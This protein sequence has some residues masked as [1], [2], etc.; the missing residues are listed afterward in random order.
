MY[1][2]VSVIRCT[3]MLLALK[4]QAWANYRRQCKAEARR[5]G[6]EPVPSDPKVK[7]RYLRM[8]LDAVDRLI[9]YH[10]AYKRGEFNRGRR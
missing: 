6:S 9:M 5:S 10:R 1:R 4:N 3:E 7:A 8:A 2:R